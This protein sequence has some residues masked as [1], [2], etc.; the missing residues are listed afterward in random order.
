MPLGGTR[1]GHRLRDEI[2]GIEMYDELFAERAH[3]VV[4]VA[5][6]AIAQLGRP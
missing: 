2:L 4:A 3:G 5:R 6:S 1:V